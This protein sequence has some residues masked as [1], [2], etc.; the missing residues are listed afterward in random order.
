MGVIYAA[1]RPWWG[2]RPHRAQ[3]PISLYLAGLFL[4][5]HTNTE[6]LAS[7]QTELHNLFLD[8]INPRERRFARTFTNLA[9][10]CILAA[11]DQC[12]QL[13]QKAPGVVPDRLF[14]RRNER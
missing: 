5:A 8:I 7:V 10:S 6:T 2:T 1:K 14:L 9:S 3:E 12:L 4:A 13:K 11:Y